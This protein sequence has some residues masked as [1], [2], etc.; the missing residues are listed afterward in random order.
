[1]ISKKK[2]FIVIGL[3]IITIVGLTLN[4]G[5]LKAKKVYVEA[6]LDFNPI[7]GF[8]VTLEKTENEHIKL[9]PVSNPRPILVKMDLESKII[10]SDSLLEFLYD[11]PLY[12]MYSDNE[13]KFFLVSQKKDGSGVIIQVKPRLTLYD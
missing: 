6:P 11:G 5:F 3:A 1:M 12:Q 13:Y 4:F 7:S 2:V 10:T 8:P 9:Y